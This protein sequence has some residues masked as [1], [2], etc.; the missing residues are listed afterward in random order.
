MPASRYTLAYQ[1][2]KPIEV[3]VEV[4]L[5][6]VQVYEAHAKNLSQLM[7]RKQY[8]IHGQVGSNSKLF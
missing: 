7:V 2:I 6:G 1:I 3:V 8:R 5:Q 4:G